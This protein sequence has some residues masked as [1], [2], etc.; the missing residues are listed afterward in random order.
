MSEYRICPIT[1][2]KLCFEDIC[3]YNLFEFFFFHSINF[4]FFCLILAGKMNENLP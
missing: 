1:I 4:F 2:P 3:T